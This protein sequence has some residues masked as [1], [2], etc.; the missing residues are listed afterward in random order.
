VKSYYSAHHES[1]DGRPEKA[2]VADMTVKLTFQIEGLEP[3]WKKLFDQGVLD[4]FKP[5]S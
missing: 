5:E 4:L 1:S 3:L 2:G